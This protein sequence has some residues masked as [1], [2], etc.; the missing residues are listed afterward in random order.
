MP[1]LGVETASYYTSALHNAIKGK[2]PS[3][4]SLFLSH[5]ADPYGKNTS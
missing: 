5:G 2:S 1:F 4:V 3:N